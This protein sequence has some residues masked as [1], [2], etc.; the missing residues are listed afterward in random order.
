M[1]IE[2]YA[3]FI[4]NLIYLFSGTNYIPYQNKENKIK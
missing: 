3:R 2:F 1:E 4:I